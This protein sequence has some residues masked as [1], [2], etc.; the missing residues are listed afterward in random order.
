MIHE[1]SQFYDEWK[2]LEDHHYDLSVNYQ[3]KHQKY[4]DILVKYRHEDELFR[5]QQAGILASHLKENEPCPVCGSTHHP[6]LAQ[7]ETSVLSS[8]ELENLSQQV[9]CLINNNRNHSGRF[10][11]K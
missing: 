3:K 4:E 2:S 6:H 5:R 11:T 9:K 7:L 10:P 8:H 1:L